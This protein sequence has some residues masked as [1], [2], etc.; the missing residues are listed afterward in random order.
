MVQEWQKA[1]MDYM[2][3]KKMLETIS[4]FRQPPRRLKMSMHRAFSGLMP[5]SPKIKEEE[6]VLS[7]PTPRGTH[8][9]YQSLLMKLSEEGADHELAFFK[10]LDLEFDKVRAF[11][12]E[13]VLAAKGNAEELTKQMD[14]L[15]ALRIKG[16]KSDQRA[17]ADDVVNNVVLTAMS[18]PP[19]ASADGGNQGT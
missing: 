9:H 17:P 12:E 8:N 18:S 1:Y 7:A 2:H 15:I 14:A 19:R 13:K 3:L 11:H 16:H 10:K 5:R 4:R 6:P